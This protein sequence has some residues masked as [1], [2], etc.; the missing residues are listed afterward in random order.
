MS[1]IKSQ[2]KSLGVLSVTR[3]E[4]KLYVLGKYVRVTEKRLTIPVATEEAH[5]HMCRLGLLVGQQIG[6][7]NLNVLNLFHIHLLR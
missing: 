3:R 2:N 5:W 7:D 4:I 6:V 1:T